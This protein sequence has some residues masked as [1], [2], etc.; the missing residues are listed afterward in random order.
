MLLELT[1]TLDEAHTQIER[2]LRNN[3]ID[4]V[5]DLLS[6][7][8][9]CAVSMGETI[10]ASEG[11]GVKT[12]EILEGYCERLYEI[13]QGMDS[14]NANA[15]RTSKILL[16]SLNAIRSSIASDIHETLETVFLP[17]KASMWDSLESVWKKADADPDCDAYVIPIPYFDRNPDGSMGKEHYE[18]LDYPMYVPVTDYRQYDFE[19]RHPDRIYI[20]NP[21]D[22]GN[23][24]TSVPPFFY[25]RN[26]KSLTDELIYI[27]YF[28]LGDPDPDNE[29]S[30]EGIRHFVTVAAVMNADKVIVQSEN[31]RKAYIKVMTDYAGEQTRGYWEKKIS[32]EGSPKF[33]KVA[34]TKKED[35][36]VPEGWEKVIRKSDGSM[37]KIIFYNTGVQALLDNDEKMLD[38]IEDVLRIFKEN[39]DDVALLWRP[40][41]LIQAT[42]TSMRPHLWERYSAIVDSYRSEGWG[43][44]D[45]SAELDRAIVLSDAYYGDGS[46][47]VELYKKTGKPIMIQ[48][49]EIIEGAG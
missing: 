31:M 19:G 13:S 27:P 12:V 44:Y 40:H 22:D 6:Q 46:S 1:A 48:N 29:E 3:S 38:K 20:H 18:G 32:G 47:V 15:D 43:I 37:K 11:E 24:V 23:F 36:E 33:D 2:E 7:C 4:T 39:K 10:E 21:Y 9:E 45:D 25:S 41:P 28:V 35:V 5:S 16:K 14:G 49:A 30:I 42:I 8:Q 34:T 17:Y 26:L